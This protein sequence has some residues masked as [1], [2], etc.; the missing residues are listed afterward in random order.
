MKK[1]LITGAFGYVGGR[2]SKYL[3]ELGKYQLYLTSRKERKLPDWAKNSQLVIYSL[4]AE[5]NIFDSLPK[6]D[7]VI[8]FAS[9]NENICIE[10]PKLAID[11]NTVSSFNLIQNAIKASVKRFIYF[12]TA[13][14]YG[15]PLKGYFDENS[16]T[17]PTHPYAYTHRAVEDYVASAHD[18]KLMEGICIRLSNSFGVPIEKEVDRWTLLVNDLSKQAVIN[19]KLVLNSFGSQKRDFIGSYD[20]CRAVEHFISL[21]GQIGNG[22]FNLG[23]EYTKSI[24]E[25]ANV[26]AERASKLFNKNFPVIRPKGNDEHWELDYSIEKLKKTGFTISNCIVNEIDQLL[27]FCQE[28]FR[29]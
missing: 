5:T 27:L 9:I 22:L 12:S 1:I 16:L 8:H 15:A 17:R 28:N 13:H 21:K 20:V 6:I 4:E 7:I 11:I 26:I 23:G 18:Q 25:M 10:S 24:Y 14:V 29:S 3:A 2:V 19:Q